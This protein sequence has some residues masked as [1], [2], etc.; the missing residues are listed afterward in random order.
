M[1]GRNVMDEPL[2]FQAAFRFLQAGVSVVLV[3]GL[4]LAVPAGSLEAQEAESQTDLTE[5]D[6]GSSKARW[7]QQ[8]AWRCLR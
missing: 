5:T 7:L 8:A 4:V 2:R 6:E 3:I 1:I